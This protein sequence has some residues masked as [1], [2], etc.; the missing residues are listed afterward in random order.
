MQAVAPATPPSASCF[1]PEVMVIR[2]CGVPGTWAEMG[3]FLLSPP[4][5][6]TRGANNK[7]THWTAYDCP[8]PAQG[9]LSL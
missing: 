1:V 7:I 3:G 9:S 6:P 2:S 4:N 5:P 8:L